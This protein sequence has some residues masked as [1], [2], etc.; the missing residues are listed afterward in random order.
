MTQLIK[1]SWGAWLRGGV[2]LIFSSL[3]V[4]ALTT[5]T[6]VQQQTTPEP[7]WEKA[8]IPGAVAA[9]GAIVQH[10]RSRPS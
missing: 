1:D 9:L 6:T 10:L 3:A 8:A 4:G 7:N 2:N 5:L